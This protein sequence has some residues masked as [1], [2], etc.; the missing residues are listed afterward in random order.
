MQRCQRPCRDDVDA[1][2]QGLRSDIV[3]GCREG[4]RLHH[5]V[6]EPTALG[7]ALDEMHVEARSILLQDRQHQ[8]RKACAS[9]QV[10][11]GSSLRCQP[12]Q[13]GGIPGVAV[14]EVRQAGGADQVNVTVPCRK[15]FEKLRHIR[16]LDWR[17][18]GGPGETLS[19]GDR[20]VR[21]RGGGH[22]PGA[23]S[24]RRELR[25]RSDPPGQGLGGG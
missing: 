13:L 4:K 15:Q 20:H 16:H 22:A 5:R 2:G 24:T 17:S 10:C 21:P 3:D 19:V 8:T 14:P 23:R 9:T 7:H 25:P 11:P 12:Q 6:Q 1:Q 18:L